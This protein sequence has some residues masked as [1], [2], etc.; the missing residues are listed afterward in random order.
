MSL[1]EREEAAADFVYSPRER[2]LIYFVHVLSDLSHS[3]GYLYLLKILN[4]LPKKERQIGCVVYTTFLPTMHFAQQLTLL[5]QRKYYLVFYLIQSCSLIPSYIIC[6]WRIKT[7]HFHQFCFISA[8]YCLI[9]N[10]AKLN[11][12]KE[13]RK[14]AVTC[15]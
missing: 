7:L 1:C 5:Y 13:R 8:T 14:V 11:V 9:D 15:F 6:M 2:V 10:C 12:L 3:P 4:K